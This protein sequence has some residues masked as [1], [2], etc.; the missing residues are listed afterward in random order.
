VVICP[1]FDWKMDLNKQIAWIENETHKLP[2]FF[3]NISKNLMETELSETYDI[4][5]GKFLLDNLNLLYV[6]F[7][8]PEIALFICGKQS[9]K[10]SPAKLWLH[11]FF[12]TTTIGNYENDTFKLGDFIE[13]QRGAKEPAANFAI[14]FHGKQM[15]KPVLSFKSAENWDI[16]ELDEKRLF[17]TKVHFVLSQIKTIDDLENVLA[18]ALKKGKIETNDTAAIEETIHNLFKDNHF[19]TYFNATEQLNEREI[20]NLEGRKLIPD[21]IIIEP[22]RTL[23][24]DFKTGQETPNHKK[25]VKEY[26]LLLKDLGFENVE[27]ELYYTEEQK[28]VRC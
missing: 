18:E 14:S 20:I 17:G 4:E 21:K 27:G 11:D 8:R 10:A 23:V 3:V 9:S 2:A 24:I 22:N 13:N 26:M 5:N 7:T 1:F 19:S 6:A 15:D 28:V 12:A 16:H 25:Q